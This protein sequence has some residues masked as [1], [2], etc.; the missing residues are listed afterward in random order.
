MKTLLPFGLI[1]ASL[2]LAVTAVN[3]AEQEHPRKI[4]YASYPPAPERQLQADADAKSRGCVSCHAASDAA[5]MHRSTSVV[6][7]CTDCH[8]GTA[9]VA[10]PDGA[11][12][13]ASC[14]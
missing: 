11:D 12:S 1:T 7:G 9:D 13:G 5:S 4:A 8:G 6:L 2:V 10:K 3:A 14:C